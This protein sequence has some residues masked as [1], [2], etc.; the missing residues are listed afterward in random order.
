M[1]RIITVLVSEQIS[2]FLRFSQERLV[3][4]PRHIEQ[5]FNDRLFI[6]Y[7]AKTIFKGG[8]FN[9]VCFF[10]AYNE[11]IVLGF[12]LCKFRVSFFLNILIPPIYFV[13]P[14]LHL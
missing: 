3:P 11:A 8:Y 4:G 1:L 6:L 9:R 2:R 10:K 12:N 13:A 7:F 14:Q 5:F